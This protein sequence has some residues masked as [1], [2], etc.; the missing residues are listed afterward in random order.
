MMNDI[1]VLYCL[2]LIGAGAVLGI[3]DWLRRRSRFDPRVGRPEWHT[4]KI[5]GNF[6]RDRK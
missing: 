2:C 5:R 6:M 4:R 3:I 1:L